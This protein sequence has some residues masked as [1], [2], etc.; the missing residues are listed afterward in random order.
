[1]PD[2]ASTVVA[3]LA[4][5]MWLPLLSRLDAFRV[6]KACGEIV[7]RIPIAW[8]RPTGDVEMDSTYRDRRPMGDRG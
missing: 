1:M 8:G 5:W 4:R 6:S 2:G 7:I 3:R